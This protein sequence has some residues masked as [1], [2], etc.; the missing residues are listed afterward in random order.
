MGAYSRTAYMA[1]KKETTE[2]V[3]VT[4]NVFV[5]FLNENI[6]TEWA[7]VFSQSIVADRTKNFRQIDRAI[8]APS[9]EINL[10]LESDLAGHFLLAV[11][12][13]MTSGRYIPV[14]SVSGT[15]QVG[16]TITG[17]SSSA[18][19][20]ITAIS[21]EGDYLLTG[22]HTGTFTDGETITGG[23]SSA[24][25]T[26][27]KADNAV[28]G[29]ES[30]FPQTSLDVTYT[31]EF[32]LDDRAYRYTG[33]RFHNLTAS[34]ED[35]VLRAGISVMARAEFSMGRVT[36]ITSS[37]AGS[38]TI[39]VDQTTGLANSDTVKL[40][41]PSTGAFID[42]SATGVKTHTINSV[43]T[44][45]TITVTN[46]ETSTAVGDLLVLAPQT[47]IYSVE[48]E[49]IWAGGSTIK[50][51]DT[52]TAAVTALA[53]DD[54]ENFEIALMN[55]LEPRHTADGANLINRFPSKVYTAGADANG[56]IVRTHINPDFLDR[57]RS[58]RQS[59]VHLVSTGQT[60]TGAT[61]FNHTI[62]IRVADVRFQP[63]SPDISEDAILNEEIPMQMFNS[64]SDGYVV[65]VLLINDTAS[66]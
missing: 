63:Y 32:G 55:D 17:G 19:A 39:T 64:T 7:G 26:L 29:H 15:F 36:A 43:A 9:G 48:K 31:V 22:A 57:V 13:A 58:G 40:Y 16:E 23:T 62:D 11:I 59:A 41:R 53:S 20:T 27:T 4:P 66:Y 54:I 38:K 10:E 35:N 14:T 47:P 28:Y 56:S 5:P 12:G 6:I 42:F 50:V 30:N 37:G 49:F 33:V 65:K 24:T 51:E 2:N 60:I 3:A 61:D 8:P 46:L 44:E 34:Q 52:I 25:A 1:I 18:T 45:L 21:S